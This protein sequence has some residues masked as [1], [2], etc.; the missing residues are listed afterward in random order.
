MKEKIEILTD[1]IRTKIINADIPGRLSWLRSNWKDIIKTRRARIIMICAGIVIAAAVITGITYHNDDD[2]E[3]YF[4][5]GENQTKKQ[6]QSIVSMEARADGKNYV[7]STKGKKQYLFTDGKKTK[8]ASMSNIPVM[9]F[10]MGSDSA[11]EAIFKNKDLN[12]KNSGYKGNIY[13]GKIYD[14]EQGLASLK[15]KGYKINNYI[16][17]AGYTDIYLKNGADNFRFLVLRQ[18]GEN[19]VL[20]YGPC[21]NDGQKTIE[22]KIDR[23][24]AVTRNF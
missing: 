3:P 24:T 7:I 21:D 16:K 13:R 6:S 14:A 8:R 9:G 18:T 20:I 23:L 15:N 1:R 19:M 11:S 10:N 2:Y 22:S 5:M 4:D 12:V 17:T